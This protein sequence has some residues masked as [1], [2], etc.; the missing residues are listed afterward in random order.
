MAVR[1]TIVKEKHVHKNYQ[2]LNQTNEEEEDA[3]VMR[4]IIGNPKKT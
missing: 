1:S 3:Y 4:T 2:K